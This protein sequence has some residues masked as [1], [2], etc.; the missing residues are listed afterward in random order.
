[1]AFSGC[2]EET[3]LVNPNNSTTLYVSNSE[4]DKPQIIT[5][6]L[7]RQGNPK[8]SRLFFDGGNLISDGPGSTDGMTMHPDDYLFV[9]IPIGLGILSPEGELLGK[10]V[11]GQVTNIG[12][13]SAGTQLFITTP[14]RLLR[15]RINANL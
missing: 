6:E 4:A 2:L 8:N 5:I 7:D 1:M 10:V 3:N 14:N 9:S 15:L 12:L 13:N 11:I